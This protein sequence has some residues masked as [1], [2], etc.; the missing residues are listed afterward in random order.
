[1]VGRWRIADRER[2]ESVT[3]FVA[4]LEVESV[5]CASLHI[6]R[7]DAEFRGAALSARRGWLEPSND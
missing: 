6:R 2:R 4:F 7:A 3:A 5:T 1:V